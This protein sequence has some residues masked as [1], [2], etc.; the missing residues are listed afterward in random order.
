MSKLIFG[1]LT[2]RY[3]FEYDAKFPVGHGEQSPR[4]NKRRQ[5]V[6]TD[7]G[8]CR[9]GITILYLSDNSDSRGG[10][11]GEVLI[12]QSDPVKVPYP[13]FISPAFPRLSRIF[14]LGAVIADG[15]TILTLFLQFGPKFRTTELI[16]GN[17]Q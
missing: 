14:G 13:L 4:Q 15:R 3:F 16:H 8:L 7:S 5:R 9:I 10:G 6:K 11:F 12:V 17:R 1:K 2:L